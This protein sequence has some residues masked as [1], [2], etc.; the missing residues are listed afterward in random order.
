MGNYI[1]PP[2]TTKKCAMPP[3]TTNSTKIEHST[4]NF[5]HFAPFRQVDL[6]TWTEAGFGH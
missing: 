4:T 1:F 5:T 3:G 6:L 2:S